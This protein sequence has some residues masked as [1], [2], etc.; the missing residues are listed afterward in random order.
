MRRTIAGL[1][2]AIFV[3]CAAHAQQGSTY[4]PLLV[5]STNVVTDGA[6]N[7]TVTWGTNFQ[8]STPFIAARAVVPT[9][10]NPINCEVVSRTAG[11]VSGWC[12]QNTPT[13]LSLAIVTT[14]LTLNAFGAIPSTGTTVMVLGRDTTQ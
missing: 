12:R 2:L 3:S 7:W 11:S 5:Q 13:L 8:S 14:G 6:G 1:L 4:P 10:N 9:G